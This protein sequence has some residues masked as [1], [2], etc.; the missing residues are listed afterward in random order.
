MLSFW[1]CLMPETF[2]I[3]IEDVSEAALV[4]RIQLRKVKA[5]V[6]MF[7][8]LMQSGKETKHMFIAY[9]DLVSSSY[10]LEFLSLLSFNS[11]L[12]IVIS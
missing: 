1:Q 2:E 10:R 5:A 4:E 12:G 11:Q 3:Q 8:Q 6:D 9:I 7:D